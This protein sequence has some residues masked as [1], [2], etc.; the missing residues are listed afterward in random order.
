MEL[1]TWTISH[2]IIEIGKK[3]PVLTIE[4]NK[5]QSDKQHISYSAFWRFVD[6]KVRFHYVSL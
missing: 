1:F 2:S 4:L 6:G 5:L 3:K